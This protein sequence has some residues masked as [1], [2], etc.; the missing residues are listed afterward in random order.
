MVT[1]MKCVVLTVQ[2]SLFAASLLEEV[3]QLL[4]RLART[5]WLPSGAAVLGSAP[6]FPEGSCVSSS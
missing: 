5:F 6:R 2:Y 3:S 4:P 1:N